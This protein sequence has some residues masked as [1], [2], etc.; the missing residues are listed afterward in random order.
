MPGI[1][2][3][4]QTTP[5]DFIED[6]LNDEMEEASQKLEAKKSKRS[7]GEYFRKIEELLEKKQ[8][9]DD[10]TDYEWDD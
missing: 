6:F 5:I 1:R 9:H 10:L 8:L 4:E 7:S 2:H 3:Q